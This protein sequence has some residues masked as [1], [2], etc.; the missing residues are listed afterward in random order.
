MKF[1]SWPSTSNRATPE[2][3]VLIDRVGSR[4]LD[5]QRLVAERQ[6]LGQSVDEAPASTPPPSLRRARRAKRESARGLSHHLAMKRNIHEMLF[7]EEDMSRDFVAARLPVFR[8]S[9]PAPKATQLCGM[10]SSTLEFLG[11]IGSTSPPSLVSNIDES[12]F[13][14]G[15]TRTISSGSKKG[16]GRNR[17]WAM[18]ESSFGG[19]EF[20]YDAVGSLKTDFQTSSQ[21][22]GVW[23]NRCVASFDENDS[24]LVGKNIVGASAKK[25]DVNGVARDAQTYP[26]PTDDKAVKEGR[27]SLPQLR[28]SIPTAILSGAPTDYTEKG[29]AKVQSTDGQ[30]IKCGTPE[31]SPTKLTPS[32]LGTPKEHQVSRAHTLHSMAPKTDIIDRGARPRRR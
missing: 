32:A 26:G 13:I 28:S 8:N 29:K 15:L 12:S 3:P 10:A 22:K 2:A 5:P 17:S 23:W 31:P 21:K 4:T 30:S 18:R 9:T 16:H 25:D 7:K 27:L 1:E 20:T 19:E 14:G 6:N 11:S 24:P